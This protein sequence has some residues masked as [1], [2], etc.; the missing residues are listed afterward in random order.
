MNFQSRAA[1]IGALL[2]FALPAFP[3]PMNEPPPVGAILDLSGTPIPGGGDGTFQT[4]TVDFT[5][6]LSNTAITFAFRE[7]PAFISFEDASVVD[8]TTS[9]S[10]LLTNGDFS[11]GVYTDNGN[12][13][14]PNGWTYANIFGAEAGGVVETGSPCASGGTPNCWY[15]GA[16]QAYDAISQTI[17]TTVGNNYQISFNV[18]DNSACDTNGGP[19]CNFSDLS[20]NGNVTGTGGNGID[21]LAYALAGLPAPGTTP[22]PGSMVLIG[23]G[24]SALYF[25]RRRKA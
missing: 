14:T 12:G 4:Y 23:T 19:P 2:T 3:D 18:A 16:V 21:V 9:S 6:A 11:G 15:D 17:A 5:A 7:D 10:N 13:A 1:I 25:V 8:L 22:E 20:T 24:L